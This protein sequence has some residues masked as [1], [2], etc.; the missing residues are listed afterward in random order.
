MDYSGYIDCHCHLAAPEFEEDLEFVIQEAKDAGV[1]GIVVVPEFYSEFR[2]TLEICARYSSFLHPCL[3]IHPVQKTD[4]AERSARPDDMVDAGPFIKENHEKLVAIG[5]VGLDFTPFYTKEENSKEG[6]RQVLKTQI[7]LAKRYDLPLNVHSRSAGRPTI[8]EL[9]ENGAEKVLLHA[10]SGNAKS[11]MDGVRAG[12]FF[13][14]PPCVVRSEQKQKLVEI[15]PIENILLETDSP[16]LGPEKQ[17]RNVPRNIVVSCD[18]IARAKGL[19]SEE[20]Q[21]ITSENAFK[22][23]PRLKSFLKK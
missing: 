11:A 6:Q 16:A 5:E 12:Y 18:F 19:S 1:K 3:G 7:N 20:V 23:F 10:Y 21:R 13:S 14:I 22:L 15:L 2:R 9:K 17:V 4:E 8:K